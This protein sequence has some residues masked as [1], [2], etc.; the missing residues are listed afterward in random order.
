MSEVDEENLKDLVSDRIINSDSASDH[1]SI[2]IQSAPIPWV[3][4]KLSSIESSKFIFNRDK[5]EMIGIPDF[6]RLSLVY[7]VSYYFKVLIRIEGYFLVKYKNIQAT[8]PQ[9]VEPFNV[10]YSGIIVLDMAGS[11]FKNEKVDLI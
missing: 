6:E 9:T 11:S 3:L 1:F 10:H 2:L 8:L 4:S 5:S 7:P